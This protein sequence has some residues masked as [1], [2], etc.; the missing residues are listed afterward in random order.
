MVPSTATTF[1]PV[2]NAPNVRWR[3]DIW[4]VSVSFIRSASA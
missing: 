3:R 1:W 2:V 4:R